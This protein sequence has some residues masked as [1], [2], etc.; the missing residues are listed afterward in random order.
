[1]TGLLPRQKSMR[2]YLLLVTGCTALGI[3]FFLFMQYS[4]T[5]E[6]PTLQLQTGKYIVVIVITNILGLLIF[7]L[8]KIL[9]K[10]IHWKNN[11]LFRLIAGL[12]SNTIIVILF[13]TLAG[14][15]VFN[16]RKAETL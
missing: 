14:N 7:Q 3:L 5:G 6:F 9:D 11:F 2:K 8:D 13:F 12:R 1:M 16:T 10:V 15:Y 4:E